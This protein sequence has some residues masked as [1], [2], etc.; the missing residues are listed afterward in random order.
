MAMIVNGIDRVVPQ[1][2]PPALSTAPELVANR[3]LG[4][5]INPFPG[6]IVTQLSAST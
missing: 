4:I 6:A 2:I 5:S 1:Y 3:T